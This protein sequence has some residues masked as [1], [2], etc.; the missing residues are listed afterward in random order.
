MVGEFKVR[1]EYFLQAVLV[2]LVGFTMGQSPFT[3]AEEPSTAKTLRDL[4]QQGWAVTKTSTRN[5][6]LPGIPPYESLSRVVSITTY[7]LERG[8]ETIICEI[9][10]DSQRDSL[11]EHCAEGGAN[12]EP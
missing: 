10:Y 6:S 9:A 3:G 8:A 11:E 1:N 12:Q 7:S 5:V 2:L 4:R